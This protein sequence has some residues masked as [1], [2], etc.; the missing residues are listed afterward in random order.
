MFEM[1]EQRTIDEQR[2][3]YPITFKLKNLV[4]AKGLLE[5]GYEYD[6]YY[7]A[8]SRDGW[9]DEILEANEGWSLYLRRDEENAVIATIASCENEFY[10]LWLDDY[11]LSD[12]IALTLN[13]I[14]RSVQSLSLKEN[15]LLILKALYGQNR[16]DLTYAQ[17][18]IS[19]E[20]KDLYTRETIDYLSDF[21]TTMA[22]IEQF[23]RI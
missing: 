10:L 6:K 13:M 8:Q 18:G 21:M 17:L 15:H 14:A 5:I 9:V 3:N 7:S 4:I 23:K 11:R 16:T 1:K 19:P 2:A 22:A 20:T 12:P